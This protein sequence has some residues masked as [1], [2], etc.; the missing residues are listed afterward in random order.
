VGILARCSC[1]KVLR[2]KDEL[3]GKRVK[4]PA[5]GKG[6]TFPSNE[7]RAPAPPA[8]SSPSVVRCEHE[9]PSQPATP[10]QAPPPPLVPSPWPV[11]PPRLR[12]SGGGTR[13]CEWCAE[14]IKEAALQCPHCHKW[15]GDI[16]EGR[17]RISACMIAACAFVV[18]LIACVST[19]WPTGAWHDSS[20]F[21]MA[22]FLTNP[23]GWCVIAC[24]IGTL[25]FTWAGVSEEIRLSRKTGLDRS[26]WW[27]NQ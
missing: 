24:A 22:E 14:S 3:A 4:C 16:A 26:F 17:S 19:V 11:D 8:P 23:S 21:S 27:R 2:A 1:G 6:L 13:V 9:S 5:C 15:R 7:L 20:G 25:L 12:S 18:L 10:T